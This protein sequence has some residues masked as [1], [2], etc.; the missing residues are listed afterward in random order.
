MAVYKRRYRPYDGELTPANSRFVV[1]PKYS[2]ATI[3]DSKPFLAFF[4]LTTM[5]VLGGALLIYVTHN[6]AAQAL[7]SMQGEFRMAIDNFFFARWLVF[8]GFIAFFVTAWVGPVLVSSDLAHDALPLYLSRPFS[9]VDYVLGKAIVIAALVSVITW[10]PGLLLFLL[11]ANLERSGWLASNWYIAMAIVVSSW[12]WIAI[13][14]MLA[15]ALSAWVK[16]RLAAT[17][18]MLAL[19]TVIPG[20]GEAINED[21]HTKWGHLLN[22]GYLMNGV[23]YYLFRVPFLNAPRHRNVQELPLWCAWFMLLAVICVCVLLLNRRLKARE[24]VRG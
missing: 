16:W 4:I 24:V 12:I 8:Q 6:A 19:F 2:F 11:N 3:F 23:A 7:M 13:L 9:R 20:F 21:L 1:L 14:A 15:L 22:L 18:L 10:I 5:P 17:G